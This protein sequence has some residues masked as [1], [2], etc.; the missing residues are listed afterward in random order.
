MQTY[1]WTSCKFNQRMYN[2]FSL[3][4]DSNLIIKIE[5]G[6]GE[7]AHPPGMYKIPRTVAL[8]FFKRKMALPCWKSKKEW[9]SKTIPSDLAQYFKLNN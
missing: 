6:K 9:T 3:S 7:K 4:S 2:E 8:D 5:G 1:T